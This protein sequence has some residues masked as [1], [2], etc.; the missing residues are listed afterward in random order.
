VSY[1]TFWSGVGLAAASAVVAAGWKVLAKPD[2]PDVEDWAIGFDLVVAAVGL[3][4]AFF[5]V[6]NDPADVRHLRF[7]IFAI[8]LVQLFITAIALKVFGYKRVGSSHELRFSAA[9]VTTIF[10]ILSLA[11]CWGMNFYASPLIHAWQK[12]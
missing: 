7:Y 2:E 4:I 6:A 11:A 12:V 8:L 1:I 10:G 3:Q 9:L 5:A